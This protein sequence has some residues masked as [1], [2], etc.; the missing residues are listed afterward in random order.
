MFIQYILSLFNLTATG[1]HGLAD[2]ASHRTGIGL[3]PLATSRKMLLVAGAA[4]CADVLEAFD[5]AS[6]FA[7][8]VALEFEGLHH[9]ANVVFFRASYVRD[10]LH[11]VEFGLGTNIERARRPNPVDSRE[12]V[13]ESFVVWDGDT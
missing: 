10:F 5:V 13:D 4:V 9:A 1:A 3:G 6:N 2:V 8:E 7:L 12:A 11:R